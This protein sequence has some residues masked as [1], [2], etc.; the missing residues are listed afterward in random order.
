MLTTS[1]SEY[2]FVHE[3]PMHVCNYYNVYQTVGCR[4]CQREYIP[5][6]L[7]TNHDSYTFP[8][9]SEFRITFIRINIYDDEFQSAGVNIHVY[10]NEGIC[11]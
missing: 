9:F 11:L 2:L 1:V 5:V 10:L 3:I 7:P 8:M 4:L 6:E